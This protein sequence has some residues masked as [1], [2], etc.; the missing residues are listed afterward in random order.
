MADILTLLLWR[1]ADGVTFGGSPSS[2]A[3]LLTFCAGRRGR[4]PRETHHARGGDGC[5]FL[6]CYFSPAEALLAALGRK[7]AGM[8][9][10]DA[11]RALTLIFGALALPPDD[12]SLSALGIMSAGS[13]GVSAAVATLRRFIASHLGLWEPRCVSDRRHVPVAEA[14]CLVVSGTRLLLGAAVS[15]AEAVASRVTLMIDHGGCAAALLH[16][17]PDAAAV[18]RV[19]GLL[20]RDGRAS[21][22]LLGPAAQVR[23]CDGRPN[24]RALAARSQLGSPDLFFACRHGLCPA[25]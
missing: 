8:P 9:L 13:A 19:G 7:I 20:M 17:G 23:L 18:L 6:V 24:S 10:R 21:A 12:T 22:V 11:G 2:C 16:L 5:T 14:A 15:L 1:R 3:T 4:P 25:P